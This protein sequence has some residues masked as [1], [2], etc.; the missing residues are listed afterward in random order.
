MQTVCFAT[1]F[2]YE[3]FS[4]KVVESDDDTITVTDVP[5]VTP[6]GDVVVKKMSLEASDIHSYW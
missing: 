4:G 1:I 6:N 3:Q 5:I 2:Y